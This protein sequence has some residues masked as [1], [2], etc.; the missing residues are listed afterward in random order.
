MGSASNRRWRMLFALS[1]ACILPA[2]PA[3]ASDSFDG[4]YLSIPAV[5]VGAT[6]YNNVKITV[7]Q[8]LGVAGGTPLS[9]YDVYTANADELTIPSVVYGSNTYT[10]VTIIVGSVVSVG[11]AGNT[12]TGTVSNT[13]VTDGMANVSVSLT[14]GASQSTSTDGS[15]NYS[16][17]SLTNGKYVVKPIDALWK[18]KPVSRAETMT[19]SAASNQNFLAKTKSG[20][21][22]TL[23]GIVSGAIIQNVIVSLNGANTG[24][25]LTDAG[26]NYSFDGLDPGTYTVSAQSTGYSFNVLS[27]ITITA[28]NATAS[29]LVAKA[30]PGGSLSLTTVNPLP[31]ATA[32]VAYSNT[33]VAR[34]S[35]GSAPYSY[36]SDTLAN[37]APPYGMIVDINGNLTGTPTDAGQYTFGVC[38]VDIAGR[39]MA[40]CP[41][42]TVNVLSA[43]EPT[44]FSLSYSSISC[45]Q[46]NPQAAYYNDTLTYTVNVSGPVDSQVLDQSGL[47]PVSCG[48]WTYSAAYLTCTRSSTTESPTTSLTF[49]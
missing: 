3:S 45:V 13:V 35:G 28:S 25:T 2:L 38:P 34:I 18:F 12:I 44:S 8:V 15:G 32:G 19:G 31:Q 48:S 27:P 21:T 26:G 30:T 10:N 7:S 24:S 4:T 16:F 23:S 20:Q 11:G 29:N 37:G 1:T 47:S 14:G 49:S 22:Y 42:T 9:A 39:T 17:S 36:Q 5:L 33:T 40:T 41:T 46:T 43:A 6:T